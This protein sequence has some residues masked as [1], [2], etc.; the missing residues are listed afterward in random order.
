MRNL[1]VTFSAQ[2]LLATLAPALFI[3]FWSTGFIV[4]R[5]ITPHADGQFFL[6]CRF[7]A[8]AVVWG[9][10]AGSAKGHWPAFRRATQHLGVGAMM[11]G[12]YLTFSFW[13][14]SRGLPAGIM[15]LMG[16]LQPLLTAAYM[17]IRGKESPSPSMWWGL[18]IGFV[19]VV[20][21]LL[22]RINGN[23]GTQSL[24]AVVAGL[25][26]VVAV[27]F[28]T[29][30]QKRLQDDDL[31][32]ANALQNVGAMLVAL[33]GLCFAGAIRWDGT[34]ALWGLLLWSVIVTSIFAQGL[35][36]WM[37]RRTGAS[38]VTALM[39]LVPPVAALIAYV[40][41]RETLTV[42]QLV[43]FGFALTGVVLAR[44]SRSSG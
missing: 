38:H 1:A 44:R 15:A 25:L 29:L 2:K 16:A 20:F 9:V 39:L 14:V 42:L 3:F 37:L 27:T 11:M 17:L 12:C 6:L 30:A 35:L 32:V 31:R 41:F 8:A 33:F 13:A 24:F 40:I 26:A 34:G 19:G 43:G 10:I 7:A 36:M 18:T 5:A 23:Q 28:G 21:V 4:A 22:P